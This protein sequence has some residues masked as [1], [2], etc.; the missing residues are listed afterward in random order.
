MVPFTWCSLLVPHASLGSNGTGTRTRFLGSASSVV[1]SKPLHRERGPAT[2]RTRL[3]RH[4]IAGTMSSAQAAE[5]GVVTIQ[6]GNLKLLERFA[7]LFR[8]DP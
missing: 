1:V 7:E 8:I 3:I 2:V 4:L 6:T 5:Q